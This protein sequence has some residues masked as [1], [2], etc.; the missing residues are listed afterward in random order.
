MQTFH[1]ITIG[2]QMNRSDLERLASLLVNA[3]WQATDK[4]NEADLVVIATCGVRQGAEDRV[5]GLVPD[6]KQA[7]PDT[8]VVV[9]GCLSERTDVIERLA[10]KVDLWLPARQMTGILPFIG[11]P[12]QEIASYLDIEPRYSSSYAAY[13]PVGNGCDNFCTYCVV[14]YA[15]GREE[16]RPAAD[17]IAEVAGLVSRGYKEIILIAQNVNSYRSELAGSSLDFAGLL[18]AVNALP[19]NFWL[20]FSTSH[21]KDM[22]DDLIAAMADCDKLCEQIHLPVQAGDDAVLAAMNRKYTADDYLALLGRIRQAMN[23]ARTL[24][25]SVTTDI[26]VG[27]PGE[28]VRQFENTVQLLRDASFDMAYLAQFSPRPG[29]AA[30]KMNDDVLADEKRRREYELNEALKE[31]ALRYN[32]ALVGR[33]LEAILETKDGRGGSYARTRLAKPVRL[34]QALPGLNEGDFLRVRITGAKSFGLEG[35]LV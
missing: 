27:F 1:T 25:L 32:T 13:V 31:T 26:I 14:P 21:P 33:E 9:T 5:Y 23:Q 12:D 18:R 7:N 11:Q 2:C 19:G 3:G 34:R 6:I 10:G 4:V 17:I 16:Y 24:P 8:K 20:R 30:A 22:S 29:T 28:T 35:E 15:R